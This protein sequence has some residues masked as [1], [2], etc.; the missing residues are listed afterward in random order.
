MRHLD[1]REW[2]R[3]EPVRLT[4]REREALRRS[5][6][7]LGIE[8]AV[9]S[10]HAWLLTPGET[11]GAFEVGG[12]SVSIR[13]KL[14]IGR[15]LFLGSYA[16]GA[17]K[18]RE[19]ERFSFPDADTLVEGLARVFAASARRAFARGLFHGYRTQEEALHTVRGRIRFA[20]QMRRRFGVPMPVE[21]RYDDFTEDVLPNRLVR[22]RPNDW[23]G[24]ES[25]RLRPAR[26]SAGS[27]ARLRTWR[28]SSTRGTPFRTSCSIG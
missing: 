28:S 4:L 25:G 21:V 8:P 1:L 23:A 10:E 19:A 15:V 22:G 18:L 20:D 6:P 7:S 2:Q 3:S 27:M 14:D 16:M 11:V 5:L 17:F 26:T 12:L 13:P 9:D 24:C